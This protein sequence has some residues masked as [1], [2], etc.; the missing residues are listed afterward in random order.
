MEVFSE[1][2]LEDVVENQGKLFEYNDIKFSQWL[3]K[4]YDKLK[5]NTHCYIFINARNLAE[6]QAEAEKVRI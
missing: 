2:Y 3:P 4:I 5:D 1:S 6:L